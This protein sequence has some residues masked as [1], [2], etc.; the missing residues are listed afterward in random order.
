VLPAG[1]TT[2][3]G[4]VRAV[5][6]DARETLAPPAGAGCVR[7]TVHCVVPGETSVA[8]THVSEVTRF[9]WTT[10]IIAPVAVIGI[11]LASSEAPRVSAKDT[12]MADPEGAAA[13]C[14]VAVATTPSFI[15]PR[16]IPL[17]MH[18]VAPDEAWHWS[19]FPADV[20]TGPDTIDTD[21]MS[22]VA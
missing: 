4:T 19:V 1:I 14:T 20:A 8:L 11:A 16:L 22:D 9:G 5:F 18:V 7:E 21:T 6:E 15:V 13:N 2:L 12:G 17:T 10:L 3:V